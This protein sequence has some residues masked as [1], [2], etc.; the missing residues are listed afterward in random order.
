MSATS[1]TPVK[2]AVLFVGVL[3]CVSTSQAD[4]VRVMTA[5]A[6]AETYLEL[7]S[8]FE[9]ATRHRAVTDATATG[10]GQDSI[11]S[12]IRRGEPAGVV[13]LADAALEELIKEGRIV[14]GSR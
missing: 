13:I 8:P 14:A 7:I 3:L 4:E 5:G 6:F 11:P 1:S 9:N 2:S 10:I 12:R